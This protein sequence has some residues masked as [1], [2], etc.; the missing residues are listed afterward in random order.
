VSRIG[1]LNET[2]LHDQLK[3]IYAESHGRTEE[4]VCGFVVDVVRDDEIIE[5][6]TS[7]LGRLRRKIERFRGAYRLRIVYPVASRT[8]LV[9]LDEL[10]AELSRRRSPRRGRVESVFR[11]LAS[12]A[13]LLPD[14]GVTLEIAMVNA[15]EHRV[16][17]GRGSWR[18]QG[19]SIV[20][21]GVEEIVS[22]HVFTSGTDY[23]ALLPAELAEP[24]SNKDLAAAAGLRYRR[25]Q[26][27]TSSFR[28]MGLIEIAGK[29]GQQLLYRIAGGYS[30]HC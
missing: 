23:L 4:T 12:I 26:P 3:A 8:R 13:D 1:S 11:E 2:D 7:G 9:K 14:P 29:R 10:G 30:R 21:R 17:D 28:K 25:A 16:A 5:I 20:G 15:V 22:T 19:V 24:F 27:M 6:Q 18:R